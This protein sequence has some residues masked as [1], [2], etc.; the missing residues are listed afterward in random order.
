MSRASSLLRGSLLRAAAV[1]LTTCAS[2]VLGQ[3]VTLPIVEKPR[4]HEAGQFGYRPWYVPNTPAFDKFNRPYMRDRERD[5]HFTS[6]IQT[7]RDGRWVRKDFVGAIRDAYPTFA[8]VRHGGGTLGASITFDADDCL[9]T[10]LRIRLADDTDRDIVLFSKDYG[11]TFRVIEIPNDEPPGSKPEG[12]ANMEL[13]SGANRLTRPPMLTTLRKRANHPLG[14]WTAHYNMYLFQPRKV[15][16]SLDLGKPAL[17]TQSGLYMS[18]HAGNPSFAVSGPDKTYVTWAETTPGNYYPGVPT[19]VATVDP[20][21]LEITDRKFCGFGYP[22]NDGHNSPG[23]VM[24]P[25]GYLHVITGSHGENFMYA[26]SLQPYSTAGGMS[27]PVPMVK[28]GWLE[29]GYSRGRQSYLS[30]LGTADG[31][32]H[33]AFR[34][35]YKGTEPY[36]LDNHFG[37]LSYSRKASDGEWPADSTLMIVPPLDGYSIYYQN[38][39]KDR[40]ERIYLSYGYRNEAPSYGTAE[41]E[42]NYMGLL[43]SADS[44]EHWRLV[45]TED[46]V[47]AMS[48][49]A[50]KDAKLS[51]AVVRGVVV[52]SDG[53]PMSGVTVTAISSIATT[54][55]AGT[56]EF[57]GVLADNFP[58]LAARDGFIPATA[59][60]A[61]A[62]AKSQ[63]L[64][65]SLK[66]APPAPPTQPTSGVGQPSKQ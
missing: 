5:P 28:H 54:D 50:A 52:D 47:K 9:Y 18:R 27:E 16:D 34:Q 14:Q 11:D 3:P 8:S 41:A 65:I 59:S 23:I 53:K 29:F 17:L 43:M 2:S 10:L 48:P 44:G 12:F 60:V 7:I 6:S 61:L 55:N 38:L 45:S 39:A 36:F 46:F 56:F 37:G 31:K 22:P 66:P 30:F 13:R 21:T 58:I 49:Q 24:D 33:T 35:W 4:E 40:D 1:I 19:L 62:G 63:D 15:G 64:K 20:E 25:H 32:L 26:K 51:P 57:A 42:N